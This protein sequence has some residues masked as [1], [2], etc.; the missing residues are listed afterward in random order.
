MRKLICTFLAIVLIAP[1]FPR[2]FADL[3]NFDPEEALKDQTILAYL[4]TYGSLCIETDTCF[5]EEGQEDFHIF[6]RESYYYNPQNGYMTMILETRSPEEETV[7]YFDNYP[8]PMCYTMTRIEDGDAEYEAEEFDD[9]Y[10]TNIAWD[11]CITD[12][13][14]SNAALLDEFEA[15]DDM[16]FNYDI[17]GKDVVLYFSEDS[18]WLNMTYED[19]YLYE[20]M[21]YYISKTFSPCQSKDPDVSIKETLS[22]EATGEV[23]E[24]LPAGSFPGSGQTM[25]GTSGKLSFVTTD[26]YGNPVDDSIMQGKR[27][28]IMNIWEPWCSP[29]KKEMPDMER[30]YQKYKDSGV[31]FLGVYG[32]HEESTDEDTREVVS[33]LGVTYPV[34]RDCDGFSPYVNDGWPENYFFDGEGNLLSNEPDGGYKTYDDWEQLILRYLNG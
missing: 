14:I 31:L 21:Y 5:E 32:R 7:R 28:V 10:V 8:S 15:L 26:L 33:E 16:L 13:D 2:A 20:N 4:C 25:A 30:L 24:A 23:V 11:R 12:Y 22:K 29:C 3:Q 17:D 6:E 34:I 9:V 27:L 1:L 18:G 19:G